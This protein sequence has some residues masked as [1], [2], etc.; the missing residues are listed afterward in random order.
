MARRGHWP[1]IASIAASIAGLV[2]GCGDRT[3]QLTAGFEHRYEID[4]GPLGEGG[5]K[6]AG[7]Y[8]AAGGKYA[9]GGR[10]QAG[11]RYN[12]GGF[13]AG[14]YYKA[15]GYYVGGRYN[16]GGYYAGGGYYGG[17]YYNGGGYY[18][19]GG[20]YTGGY[21]NAGGYYG[22]GG[23]YTGGYYNVGGYYGGGGYSCGYP[24][25]LGCTGC[26][27]SCYC[28]IGN[29]QICYDKCYPSAGGAGGAQN[30]DPSSCPSSVVPNVG[31]TLGGCCMGDVCGVQMDVPSTVLPIAGGCQPR[32]QPGS[33]NPSCG[34][35]STPA[36][37]LSGCCR[38]DGTCGVDLGIIGVGCTQIIAGQIE[39]CGFGAG[40]VAGAG[41]F[42]GT[43]GVPSMGGFVATGGFVGAG[44]A[45]GA[46]A[47]GGPPPS[48]QCYA[49]AQNDCE[50]CACQFCFDNIAPCFEDAGCPA[51]LQCA[52][53]T[54]CSGIDCLNAS[55][56]GAVISQYGGPSGPSVG[57]ALPL[58]QCLRSA[59]CSCGFAP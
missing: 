44:G 42:V 3:G 26:Y 10:Y 4:G 15:G 38:P 50:R 12:A 45:A 21:Y 31:L 37:T 53:Q 59:G 2:V 34:S 17:G 52:N 47:D 16:A 19:G 29:P 55:T 48:S 43:G 57:L 9:A 23:Y 6:N 13:H 54:G 35:F 27:D 51:I 49:Q 5:S 39:F 18:G 25:C 32:N 30:C 28:S 7:G 33:Y 40:G 56:C 14:G 22:G 46:P 41:G 1:A 24:D 11:G 20:Y 8:R 36:G 58:F